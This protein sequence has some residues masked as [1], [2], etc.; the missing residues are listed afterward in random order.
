M[1]GDA[2]LG[3]TGK[4][5]AFITF[6]QS[7]K[8]SEYLN[9]LHK[10]VLE[11]GI[12]SEEPRT[13][14][15]TD[16][17]YNTINKS[18]YFRTSSLE[19]L[20]LFAETFLN[21]EGTKMIPSNI[22]ELLTLRSLAFWIMDD[23]QQVK[24]GGLTLCTDSFNSEEIS[25][26]RKALETNFNLITSIHKKRGQNDMIYERIYINKSSLEEIKPSL[27]EHMHYSMLYKINE[28]A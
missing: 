3:R 16:K 1:L 7:W 10:I 6:E 23:G 12:E 2:H 25:F 19:E 8:K 21:S 13:Y 24:K 22:S 17:R 18:L 11:E 26:L 15:R 9:F 28:T 14:T 5:Q 20:K 4:N 27:K